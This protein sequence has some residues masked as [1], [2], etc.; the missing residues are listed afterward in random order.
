MTFVFK[1]KKKIFILVL[2]N[3][4]ILGIVTDT[5]DIVHYK[6]IN[7]IPVLDVFYDE[8]EV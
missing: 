7:E 3:L 5:K 2:M 4:D 1:K 8:F 6:W